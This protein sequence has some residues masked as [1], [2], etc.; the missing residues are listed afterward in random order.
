MLARGRILHQGSSQ[1][2]D[3]RRLGY[4]LVLT[5]FNELA[6]LIMLIALIF[7]ALVQYSV[8]WVGAGNWLKDDMIE[9]A[10]LMLLEG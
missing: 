6:T 10:P 3:R 7:A 1:G 4:K 8:R 5:P 9:R 2:R